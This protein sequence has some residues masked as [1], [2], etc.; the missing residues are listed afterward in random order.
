MNNYKQKM[1]LNIV[2][3]MNTLDKEKILQASSEKD[4]HTVSINK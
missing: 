1:K 3:T 4:T 2:K